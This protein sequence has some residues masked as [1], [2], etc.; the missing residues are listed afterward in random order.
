MKIVKIEKGKEAEAVKLAVEY[1]KAGKVIA[2]PT[3]TVYGLGCDATNP[4]AVAK[5]YRIKGKEEKRALLFLVSSLAM[6]KRYLVFTKLASALAK[7]YWPGALSLILPLTEAGKKIFKRMDGGVRISS[8]PLAQAI[9]RKLASPF[10][11][12]SANISGQ[13]ASSSA[14]QVVKYFAARKYQPD[15]V[16]D[17]GPLKKSKGSTIINLTKTEPVVLRAGAV[18]IKIP[19]RKGLV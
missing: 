17:A 18:S 10:I 15:L 2:Y 19:P 11:S 16:I 13:P 14:K 1:L 12:T 5:I 4:R 8:N 7:T 3:E 9:V 6:A